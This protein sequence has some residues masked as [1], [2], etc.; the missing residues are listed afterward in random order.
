MKTYK[1]RVKSTMKKKPCHKAQEA[2]SKKFTKYWEG[3]KK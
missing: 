2:V 3:V 1:T